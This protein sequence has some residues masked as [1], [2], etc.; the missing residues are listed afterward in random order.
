MKIYDTGK[1]YIKMNY[2][3]FEKKLNNAFLS[4]IGF[5][6]SESEC[7][8]FFDFMNLLIEK[9]KVMNLTSIT[10]PDE[11]ILRHF[12]DSCMPLKFYDKICG[13]GGSGDGGSGGSKSNGNNNGY[14]GNNGGSGFETRLTKTRHSNFFENANLVDIGTGAGFPGL[15]LAI[16]CENANFI[17]TD[18]LG[19]RINFLSE[20]LDK[21]KILNVKL[22]KER[23]EDFCSQSEYRESFDFVFSRGVAK[24]SV[25]SEYCLPALKI[26]G[27]MISYKMNEIENE[28]G[29]GRNAIKT[30][31]GMFHEKHTYDLI[32]NVP[33]RCLVVIDKISKTPKAY[34]RKAGT[35]AKSPL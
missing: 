23:A 27:K 22:V 19:K 16:V 14:D 4:K 24:L 10:E 2:T 25:L 17:L 1:T 11:I 20:V 9:N 34:P 28:L 26:G 12:V 7:K 13:K 8:Q 32:E 5:E 35:P 31:G 29:E 6:L 18:T 21:I 15:P 3:E 33:S 30:L